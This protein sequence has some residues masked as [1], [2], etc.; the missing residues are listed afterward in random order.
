MV[1]LQQLL[2]QLVNGL[3]T[4][5]TYALIALGFTLIFG[6]SHVLNMAYPDL[7]TVAAYLGYV[8]ITLWLLPTAV[9][10]VIVLVVTSVL[11][12]VIYWIA[13]KPLEGGDHLMPFISTLALAGLIQHSL[14]EGF[15]SIGVPFPSFIP[16][17]RYEPGGVSI[18]L[19][20]IIVIATAALLM[21]GL[22][23]L[24]ERTKLG[25]AIRATAGDAEVAELLGID[26]RQIVR[27]VMVLSAFLAAVAGLLLA[28]SFQ[29]VGPYVGLNF[30]LKA[31]VVVIIGGVGRM[32]GAVAGGLLLGVV[33]SLTVH[34]VS[35]SYRDAVAFTVLAVILVL[36]PNGLFG[37][38]SSALAHS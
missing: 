5:S 25:K 11:G 18:G 14:A 22:K 9:A 38:R 10:L 13:I 27:S 32:E 35:T 3:L 33:E 4:G 20:Q 34:Y 17:A 8:L 24:V 21:L 23:V 36:M 2:T 19:S 31:I 15:G 37:R 16:H 12:L 7:L 28:S 30:A 29:Q 6:V 26:T 1:E